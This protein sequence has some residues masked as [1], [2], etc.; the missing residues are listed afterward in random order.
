[1]LLLKLF[2]FN[3]AKKIHLIAVIQT[4]VISAVADGR[5]AAKRTIGA[6]TYAARRS[7]RG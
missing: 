1:M 7:M 3:L 4:Q 5:P 6:C 2:Y